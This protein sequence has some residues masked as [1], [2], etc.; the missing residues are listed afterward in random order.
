MKRWPYAL[1]GIRVGWIFACSI[2]AGFGI[3]KGEFR[4]LSPEDMV[5]YQERLNNTDA[6]LNKSYQ[7][8]MGR[9]NEQGQA[10]VR[11][12][13]RAWVDFK[14]K[15]FDIFSQLAIPAKAQERMFAYKISETAEQST[16]LN[17]LLEPR[18]QDFV[19]A[20]YPGAPA[21]I[22]DA[23]QADQILNSVYRD[24]LNLLPA[25]NLKPFKDAQA[26]WIQFRD[27]Y[28]SLY[29]AIHG[30]KTNDVTLRILSIRRSTQLGLYARILVSR[31]L[32]SDSKKS[33]SIYQARTGDEPETVDESIPDLF[34]FAR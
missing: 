32:S 4:A 25:E 13:Q 6:A 16:S 31:Q 20:S 3:A 14:S 26:A 11:G 5:R 15:D 18:R 17:A 21:P 24:C 34:R 9:F 22:K 33:G 30:A 23:R 7:V 1:G 28:A 29:S 10:L 2:L 12:M 19:E 8:L 27:Q